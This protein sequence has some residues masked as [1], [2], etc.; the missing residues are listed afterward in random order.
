MAVARQGDAALA[1][2]GKRKQENYCRSVLVMIKVWAFALQ[3]IA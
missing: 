3:V 1:K 2:A